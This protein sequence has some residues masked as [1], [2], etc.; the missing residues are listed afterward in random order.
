VFYELLAAQ[1]SVS[2]LF[3]RAVFCVYFGRQI[4]VRVLYCYTVG[5]VRLFKLW[6]LL[7]LKVYYEIVFLCEDCLTIVRFKE[8]FLIHNVLCLN[9]IQSNVQ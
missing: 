9:L 6:N 4:I 3:K 7:H 1:H 2:G 8:S 5:P